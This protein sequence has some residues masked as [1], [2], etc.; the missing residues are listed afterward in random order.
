LPENAIHL[1]SSEGTRNQAY[2]YNKKVL[3]MQFHLEPTVSSLQ[4]MIDNGRNELSKGKYVQTEKEILTN[5]Q[6]IESNKK[7]LFKLLERLAEH[8]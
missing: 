3:A 1:A 8:E 4:Q 6:L 7:V 2:I 5:K